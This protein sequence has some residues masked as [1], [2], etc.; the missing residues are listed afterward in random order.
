M[1]PKPTMQRRTLRRLHRARAGLLAVAVIFCALLA[2][3]A[4]T[5]TARPHRAPAMPQPRPELAAQMYPPAGNRLMPAPLRGS[6]QVLVHQ[7]RMADDAGLSRLRNDAE[8]KRLRAQHLLV[9]FPV[10]ASLRLNPALPANRRCARPWTVRFAADMAHAFYARFGKP[11]QVNSAARTVAYQLRLQRSNGNAAAVAGEGA[12]PHL[13]GQAID[14]GKRGMSAAQLAWM[15]ATLLP[16][17]GSGKID[18]E[19]EFQQACFHISVYRSYQPPAR[20]RVVARSEVA[21]LRPVK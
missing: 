6:H 7:N 13:T 15:R 21:Q 12:S 3:A 4:P 14:F 5:R 17:M 1:Q 10:S 8:L 20:R 18:V 16:L 9:G 19:E 2:L 11:L